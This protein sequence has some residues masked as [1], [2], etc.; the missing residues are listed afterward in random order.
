[1]NARETG[2][3]QNP[4]LFRFDFGSLGLPVSW[5][6]AIVAYVSSSTDFPSNLNVVRRR[7]VIGHRARAMS[8][9]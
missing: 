3:C 7:T 1:M 8:P 9:S 6:C 4:G 5:I 2:L